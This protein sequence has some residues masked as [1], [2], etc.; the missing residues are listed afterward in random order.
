MTGSTNDDAFGKIAVIGMAGR[1]PGAADIEQFWSN[2]KAGKESIT[3]FSDDELIEDGIDPSFVHD[4]N[5]VKAAGVYE[6]TYL[7]DAE[8]FG[9]T[10]REAELLDPQHR[11]FLECSYQALEHAGYDPWRYDGRIGVFAGTG[12]TQYLFELLALPE[13]FRTTSRFAL[14]TYNDKDFLA[15]RVGYKLGLRGLCV[16]VQTACSTSLVAI[17]L[18]SQCLLNY[19]SDMVLAGGVSLSTRERSGY[20]YQEGGISSPDGH[21]RAFDASSGGIVSGS[22]AGVVVLKRL[23]DALK[24]GDSIHAVILGFGMNNDGAARVGFTAPGVD[25]QSAVVADAIA[26][27]GINPETIGYVECHGTGTPLGD[28]IEIAALTRSFREHTGK[29]QFCAI[30]SVKTNIG[31]MDTAAGVAGFTKAVLALKH[32]HIPASLHFQTP[33]PEIDFANSPFFV[34][35]GLRAWKSVD[36]PRRAGVS[37]L[38]AG[39]TN[40]HV[41]L[42]EPPIEERVVASKEFHLL[43]W[44]ARSVA[45]LNKLTQKLLQHLQEHPEQQIGDIAYTL[46]VGRRVFSHRRMLVSRNR[47]NA[48]HSLESSRLFTR[49]ETRQEHKPRVTFLFPGQGCQYIHMGKELY[50]QETVFREW[51]DRCAQILKSEL[52]LDI[53]SLLFPDPGRDQEAAAKL[54]QIQFATPGIFTIEYALAKL[55][56]AWGVRPDALI[57]HSFGEYVA[58]CLSGVFSLE[59]ALHLVSIRGRLMQSLPAGAM[60]AV[61]LAEHELSQLLSAFPDLSI[62][63]VNGPSACVVSGAREAA[64]ALEQ[65]LSERGT[66][67]RRLHVSHAAHSRMMEAILE[68]FKKEVGKV[69]LNEPQVPYISNVSGTWIRPAEATDPAYWSN[70]IRQTVQF[71]RG[72]QELLRIPGQVLLE[73][74]PGR[75]LGSLLMQYPAGTE[76]HVVLSSLPHPKDDPQT[77]FEFFLTTTGQ[78][79]LEGVQIDWGQMHKGDSPRRVP[80]PVYPFEGQH[81]QLTARHGLARSSVALGKNGHHSNHPLEQNREPLS[82]SPPGRSAKLSNSKLMD[83]YVAPRDALESA[84]AEVWREVFGMEDLG[85]KDEFSAL[86]G[87]SLLAMQLVQRMRELFQIEFSLADLRRASTIA[88]LAD[89]IVA[90]LIDA[91]DPEQLA[92]M[93][94]EVEST[95]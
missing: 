73:V 41:I 71:F 21:C 11:V 18:A 14:P 27:A 84:V 2:L 17:G 55:W 26:M 89:A 7:F 60:V 29:K 45:A 40:A 70:H 72:V 39:G 64:V 79:W 69:K 50:Q 58:A 35:T 81:Y 63:A 30:G 91:V 8:F 32:G 46:Q 78:L 93:L 77:A 12:I 85:I 80:L 59:D 86:G 52:G 57:G 13:L 36:G 94:D 65:Q 24:D 66:P 47:E 68:E 90:T 33:N 19:Q 62:A 28:P 53:R 20:F 23:S 88:D 15:T 54:N 75:M 37:S 83:D 22:G 49:I 43:V 95:S 16:T 31:H 67:Y 9:Y 6:G 74:G 42:E 56:M 5:Y 34:N 1:Y 10:P 38:G 48:I 25:G 4:P 76:R 3:F 61:M 44:S 51:I 87:H 82:A 92:G